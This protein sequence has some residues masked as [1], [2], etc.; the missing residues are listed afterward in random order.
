M[1]AACSD[2]PAAGIDTV[3]IQ[4]SDTPLDVL[5]AD[6]PEERQIGLTGVEE[7]PGGADGMLFVY[8]TPTEVRYFMLDVPTALDIWFFDPDGVLVSG[9]EM[10]PCPAEPCPIYPSSGE[11]AWVLETVAGVYE[12]D[13]G[14]VL[15]GA[16]NGVTG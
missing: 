11:V 9:T 3:A 16:P 13:V 7:I 12:F 6:T 10:A 4:V 1:G 5:V 14:A 8:E 15:S 2:A